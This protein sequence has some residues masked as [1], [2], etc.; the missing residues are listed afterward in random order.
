M[1]GFRKRNAKKPN[2]GQFLAKMAKS[3]NFLIK[4]LGTFFSLLQALINC[5]VSEKI[6]ERFS[7]NRVTYG[8]TDGRESLGLQRLRRETKNIKTTET[9]LKTIT[10]KTEL[11]I[12]YNPFIYISYYSRNYNQNDYFLTFCHN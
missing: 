1:R 9:R 6:N 8:C 4:A 7:S 10:M 2:F 5:K 3:G 11:T 12:G